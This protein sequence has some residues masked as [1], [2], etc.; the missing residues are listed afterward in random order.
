MTGERIESWPVLWRKSR[1][2]VAVTAALAVTALIYGLTMPLLALVLERQGVDNGLIGINTAVQSL[3]V[4]LI[5]PAVPRLMRRIGA[6]RLMLGAIA[7]SAALF[8]VM[9]ALP[10]VYLWFPLRFALGAAGSLLWIAGETWVNQIAGDAKRGRVVAFFNMAVTG[11]FALGPL[12]LIVTGT[13]G[14]LPF[15]VSAAIMTAA[16]VPLLFVLD[17]APGFEGRPSASLLGFLWLAPVTMFVSLTFAAVEG[18]MLTFLPIYGLRVGLP[19]SA[20]VTLITLMGV[21]GIAIQFPIGW[22][23]DRMERRLLTAL[24]VFAAG[25]SAVAM[26]FLLP[27]SPW[28]WIYVFVLGGFCA[29]LYT[30]GM[31]LLGE[32]FRGA[33][34]AAA[35]T[36]F[37]AM[38]AVGA[39]VGPPLGG[40]GMELYPPH[41]VP[42][43][44]A[45]ILFAYLPLPVIAYM[46]RRARSST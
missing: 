22:L 41:G 11:G 15:V 35:S 7:T 37:G 21:G 34:L 12:I 14:W 31:V 20:A 18:A 38:W 6:P 27:L 5:A 45:L 2:L 9:R 10:D 26:P 30:L 46:R 44:I 36:L 4:F 32:R 28:N 24:C 40:L 42:A 3:A 13:E 16:A 19:E 29:S 8:L 1:T 33:D 43:A 25:A 39:I 17:S 23:A